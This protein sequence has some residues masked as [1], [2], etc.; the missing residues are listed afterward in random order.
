MDDKKAPC[1]INEAAAM[2]LD[3]PNAGE[4]DPVQVASGM[5][6]LADRSKDRGL[7][8]RFIITPVSY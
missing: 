6:R 3:L 7:T 2:L 1:L 8:Y 5:R 4:A